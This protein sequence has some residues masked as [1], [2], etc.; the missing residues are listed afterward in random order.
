MRKKVLVLI[1]CCCLLVSAN[2]FASTPVCDGAFGLKWEASPDEA[3]PIA[4]NNGWNLAKSAK[5]PDP[6]LVPTLM[7]QYKGEIADLKTNITLIYDQNDSAPMSLYFI[8]ADFSLGSAAERQAHYAT[9]L[10]K[11]TEQFGSPTKQNPANA[12]YQ[13]AEWSV[14]WQK[15][16]AQVI[17]AN[18]ELGYSLKYQIHGP[19]FAR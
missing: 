8:G 12:S 10:T 17:L 19:R 6:D 13:L 18:T 5:V 14:P 1:L 4:V 16:K 7:Q 9:M 3:A 11:L 15:G 2:A